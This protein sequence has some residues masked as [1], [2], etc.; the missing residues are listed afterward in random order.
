[1]NKTEQK[2]YDESVRKFIEIKL[3]QEFTASL[4]PMV[5]AH[6]EYISLV[7]SFNGDSGHI[8][9]ASATQLDEMEE[10]IDKALE[11]LNKACFIMT[12]RSFHAL[13]HDKAEPEKIDE[14]RENTNSMMAHLIREKT[15]I[16]L[17]RLEN[18]ACRE[19][20]SNV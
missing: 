7:E 13:N 20:E 2:K 18:E 4:R 17:K 8:N 10:K 19:K 16:A 14:W 1:M 9:L 12:Q 15:C 6:K 3:G 5:E 11:T